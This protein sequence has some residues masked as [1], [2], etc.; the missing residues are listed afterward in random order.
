M[1]DKKNVMQSAYEIKVADENKKQV[2]DIRQGNFRSV[3]VC[4]LRRTGACFEYEV[5]GASENLGQ[6]QQSFECK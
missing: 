1:S 5:H 2:W 3:G 4:D 6:Q